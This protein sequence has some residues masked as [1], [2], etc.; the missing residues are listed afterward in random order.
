[1]TDAGALLPFHSLPSAVLVGAIPIL[2]SLATRLYS[3]QRGE[4]T[5][6]GPARPRRRDEEPS[7]QQPHPVWTEERGQFD[8][9]V[10]LLERERRR[11]ARE[12]HD[13]TLQGLGALHMLLSAAR[14]RGRADE[15]GSA[16]D[17]ALDLVAREIQTLRHLLVDLRPPELDDVGLQ[18]AIEK[19]VARTVALGGPEVDTDIRL[20]YELGV[21]PHRLAAELETVVYRI[22]QEALTNVVKH[23]AATRVEIRVTD[24]RGRVDVRIR[25]DGLGFSD[26]S[27]LSDHFGIVGMRERAAL[28]GGSL[29]VLSSERGTT[30]DLVAP[31]ARSR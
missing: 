13:E 3:R 18:A 29:S 25:D 1:M 8:A 14:R 15:L 16:V 21:T 28:I 10:Q 7:T 19:V 27:A 12:L 24:S 26:H 22:V 2:M 23:A 31:I 17:T 4:R 9:G 6:S 5:R 20:Q 30:V 11:W